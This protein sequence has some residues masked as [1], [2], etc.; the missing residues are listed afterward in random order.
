[1]LVMCTV[2]WIAAPLFGIQASG[3]QWASRAR[4]N[5]PEVDS[6]LYILKK[7]RS[8][9][10]QLRSFY[11]WLHYIGFD[12]ILVK[13]H[14]KRGV[15]KL[16]QHLIKLQCHLP[17]RTNGRTKKYREPA[18]GFSWVVRMT[19]AER[20]ERYCWWLCLLSV[21]SSFP[22]TCDG[23]SFSAMFGVT[24][25]TVNICCLVTIQWPS[26]IRE[27]PPFISEII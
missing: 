19:V 8:L 6:K 16:L 21:E 17:L 11:S 4:V 18:L 15:C 9:S 1:M 7:A 27:E 22:Q 2:S 20:L 5:K 23:T 14:R 12:K 24:W 10:V 26:W 3:T 13:N 25:L